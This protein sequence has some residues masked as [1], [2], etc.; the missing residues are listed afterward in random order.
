VKR[1][2]QCGQSLSDE[3]K[4]CFKCG[5]ASFEPV[6]DAGSYQPPQVQQQPPQV[7]QPPPQQSYYQQPS[8]QPAYNTP[9][10]QQPNTSNETVSV[11]MNFL[12]LFLMT[13][14]IVGLIY[15][16]VIAASSR[17]R[18]YKNLGIAWLIL[19]AVELVIGLVAFFFVRTALVEFFGGIFSTFGYYY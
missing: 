15:A 2:T 11:G 16:I 5:G 17:K 9:Y 1:C 10:Y 6:A 7:Q 3:T 12:F 18:S 13:I 19:L 4:F 14:P 8:A